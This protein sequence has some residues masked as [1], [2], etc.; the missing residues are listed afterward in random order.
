MATS[1]EVGPIPRYRALSVRMKYLVHDTNATVQK[2]R[3]HSKRMSTTLRPGS[4]TL[5]IRSVADA[6]AQCRVLSLALHT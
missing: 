6:L 3:H 2:A 4:V 1:A 5:N